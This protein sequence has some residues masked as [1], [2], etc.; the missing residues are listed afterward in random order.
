MDKLSLALSPSLLPQLSLRLRTDADLAAIADLWVTTWQEVM[1]E[2]D[3]SARLPW[4]RDHLLAL[5]T[6][7]AVTVCAFDP[8]GRLLGFFTLA[9]ATGYLDQLAVASEAKGRGAAHLLLDEARRRSPN[10]L[11]LDVNQDNPRAVAF[12]EREGFARVA[13]GVNGRSGRKTWRLQWPNP[14]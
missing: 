2:I 4:F 13:E 1:P 5:E 7:G 12:Y 11:V 3:F 9:V 8:L 6:A 14:A 10:G